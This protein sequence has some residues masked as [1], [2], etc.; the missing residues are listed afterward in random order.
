M[1]NSVCGIGID[2]TNEYVQVSFLKTPKDA[3]E[4][5]SVRD[6]E[7]RYLIPAL[8]YYRSEN[9]TWYF[10]E[11]AVFN[12]DSD[13]RECY[14][15]DKDIIST[16]DYLKK[17]IDYALNQFFEITDSTLKEGG[18]IC[19]TIEKDD[20][21]AYKLIYKSLNDLGYEDERVRIINHD[22]AFI[23]YVI[24]QKRDLWSKD[25]SLI[26][27]TKGHM[28]YRRFYENKEKSTILVDNEDISESIKYDMTLDEESS[29][30]A[31][32]ILLHFLKEEF[33]KSDVGTVYL[34]GVGFYGEWEGQSLI[35]MC[36]NRRVFK[37]YNLYVLG[38]AFAA[39]K[40]YV[41]YKK[42]HIFRSTGR[43]KVSVAMLLENGNEEK[44]VSLSDE[45]TNWYEAGA[46][47]NVILDDTNRIEFLVVSRISGH[48]RIFGMDLSDF[49]KRPNKATRVNISL[50]YKNDDEFDIV[51]EDL[52]FGDIFKASGKTVRESISVSRLLG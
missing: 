45:G 46:I 51:I 41:S 47:A 39:G 21:D 22:E 6:T 7:N 34:T 9:D 4:S 13:K 42:N 30:K 37:G 27:F 38:A 5:L 14:S 12:A 49:P 31:D 3:P 1:K 33:S 10:G 40:K 52:G 50:A 17:Y 24:N 15:F 19:V 26:D 28:K 11:E 18:I 20:L 36:R 43:T 16:Y 8:M 25:V 2:M 29:R 44:I 23:Y 32:E 48:K 35:E